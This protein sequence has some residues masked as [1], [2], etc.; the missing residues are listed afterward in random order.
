VYQ[1]TVRRHAER[2]RCVAIA[3]SQEC[4]YSNKMDQDDFVALV[5]NAVVIIIQLVQN[6]LQVDLLTEQERVADV[7]GISALANR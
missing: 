2:K 4:K 1:K 5:T 3:T 6:S 7:I